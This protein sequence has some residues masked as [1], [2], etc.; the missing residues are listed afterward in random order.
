VIDDT[1][2]KREIPGFGKSANDIGNVRADRLAFRAR[3][4]FAARPLEIAL[5]VGIGDGSGST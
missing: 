2:A 3:R 4:A 1:V 5:D